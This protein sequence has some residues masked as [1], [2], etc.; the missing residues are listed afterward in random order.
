[1]PTLTLRP[2]RF[3]AGGD[4]VARDDDGRVVFVRG[5]LPGET[6]EVE[7]V[8]AKRDWARARAVAV[9][10]ASPDRVVPP[11]PSRR[12]GCGGCGWQHLTL[13][14][15]RA[16]RVAIVTDALRRAGG[17]AEPVVVDGG[18]VAAFGY[19]T[20]VRVAATADGA[21]G[22]RAE[23]THDVVGAPTCLIADPRLAEIIAGLRLDPDV[24]VTVRWSVAEGRAGAR[25]DQTRGAV[26]G[27]PDGTVIG[28]DAVLHRGRG[29]PAPAG[30]DGLVLPV[31]A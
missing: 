31:R 2:D 29:R 8:T 13:E 12:A 26:R 18:G 30:L 20:T 24:E 4:A 25:W 7:V 28:A 19:R 16:A 6:V 27:L 15:Q 22:F 5:A 10:E 11:C 14:A 23:H 21:A 1:M 17:V 3:A 9:L